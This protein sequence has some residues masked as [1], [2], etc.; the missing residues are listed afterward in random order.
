[1]WLQAGNVTVSIV[2]V[3]IYLIVFGLQSIGRYLGNDVII[4]KDKDETSVIT[5]PRKLTYIINKDYFLH[6]SSPFQSLLWFNLILWNAMGHNIHIENGVN[7]RE[8]F[9][10]AF[11]IPINSSLDNEIFIWDA[12]I[13]LHS[14]ISPDMIPTIRLKRKMDMVSP[15]S[16]IVFMKVEV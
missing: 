11:S 2:L 1:M 15:D 4:F 7:L 6:Y 5:P 12:K 14:F 16:L 13:H 8:H 10:N 9:N 3:A